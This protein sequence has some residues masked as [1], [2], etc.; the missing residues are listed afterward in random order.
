M[1]TFNMPTFRMPTFRIEPHEWE[2]IWEILGMEPP[3]IYPRW[4]VLGG[5]IL[6]FATLTYMW[7]CSLLTYI[8]GYSFAT[9]FWG[10]C[11]T[12]VCSVPVSRATFVRFNEYNL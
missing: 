1:P 8:M 6:L 5:S 11:V 3:G 2:V 7:I 12:H 4:L 9:C 10:R